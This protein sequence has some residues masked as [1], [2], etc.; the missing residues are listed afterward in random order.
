MSFQ[1]YLDTIKAKTG[2]TPEDFKALAAEKGLLNESVKAG[3]IVAW[4]KNDFGLGHGHAMAIY[5]VFKGAKEKTEPVADLI[6][7]H[8][9][10]AR[11]G[12]RSVFDS[13]VNDLRQFGDDINVTAAS[14]YLI[15]HRGQ[16]KMGIVQ[17]TAAR[18]DIG[19]KLKGAVATTR[20]EP[21][22]TW[23]SMVTHRVRI[24]KSGDIDEELMNWFRNAY[25]QNVG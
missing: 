21:A 8:F 1:G 11:A 22:G 3:E 14:S 19:I 24:T 10:G 6:A 2:K 20:F 23:N 13:L 4:L 7:R 9:L 5:T 18:M 12:W 25:E 16:R 15:I 17:L